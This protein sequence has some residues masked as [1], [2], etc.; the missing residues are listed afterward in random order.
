MRRAICSTAAS[1]SP[2]FSRDLSST[3]PSARADGERRGAGAH[4]LW[5]PSERSLRGASLDALRSARAP[6][7]RPSACSEIFWIFFLNNRVRSW[8][9]ADYVPALARRAPFVVAH[10]R[11]AAGGSHVVMAPPSHIVRAPPS[12]IVMAPPSHKVMAPPSHTLM[13]PPSHVVMAPPSHTLMAPPSHIVMAPSSHVVMA[14]PSHVVMAPPSHV[15]MA[16][17]RPVM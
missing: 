11:E 3:D 17:H 1:A 5:Y 14:P 4:P 8:H 16:L 12:H 13:A 15:V 2:R 6:R 7:R 9:P 10:R